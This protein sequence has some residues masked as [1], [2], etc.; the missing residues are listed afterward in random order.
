MAAPDTSQFKPPIRKNADLTGDQKIE[1]MKLETYATSAITAYCEMFARKGLPIDI[2][3]NQIYVEI[4][5]SGKQ[6]V[7]DHMLYKESKPGLEAIAALVK[8]GGAWNRKNTRKKTKLPA[9]GSPESIIALYAITALHLSEKRR[10]N[11][12]SKAK[13]SKAVTERVTAAGLDFIVNPSIPMPEFWEGA[14]VFSSR[15]RK[16]HIEPLPRKRR[17]EKPEVLN[18]VQQLIDRHIIS[19]HKRLNDQHIVSEYKYLI[20][21]HKYLIGRHKHLIGRHRTASSSS[22]SSSPLSDIPS[23]VPE[24]EGNEGASNRRPSGLVINTIAAPEAQTTVDAQ[25]TRTAATPAG[26]TNSNMIVPTT[27]G[28]AMAPAA[29]VIA[30]PT[31]SPAVA[32]ATNAPAAPVIAPPATNT[33]VPPTINARAG[34]GS[35]TST[36]SSRKRKRIEELEERIGILVQRET[37]LIDVLAWASEIDLRRKKTVK[38]EQQLADSLFRAVVEKDTRNVSRAIRQYNEHN[39]E[40]IDELPTALFELKD[41]T[42]DDGL[43]NARTMAEMSLRIWNSELRR[44]VREE[45]E[46]RKEIISDLT[47]VIEEEHQK[48]GS[49]LEAIKNTGKAD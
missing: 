15:W 25:A 8:Q 31:T 9:W 27:T 3:V 39:E 29:P 1:F 37:A 4:I 14:K 26:T 6:A 10:V 36:T 5:R 34:P 13:L 28:T 12:R 33:A 21:R 7:T 40:D 30:P 42:T 49:I 18:A 11:R 44:D 48:T 32:P 19:K 38:R 22:P 46:R 16:K 35:V 20:G 45:N 2:D 41:E 47:R 24:S 43:M 23:T 17:V